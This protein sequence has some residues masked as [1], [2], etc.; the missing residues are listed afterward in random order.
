MLASILLKEFISQ[1]FKDL[2]ETYLT[3][4]QYQRDYDITREENENLSV[5]FDYTCKIFTQYYT[6]SKSNNMHLRRAGKFK[7][8]SLNGSIQEKN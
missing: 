6:T 4:E 2:F 1:T 3:S 8:D 7:N 5:L